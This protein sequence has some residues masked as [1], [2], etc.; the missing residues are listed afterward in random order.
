[1]TKSATQISNQSSGIQLIADFSGVLAIRPK[2]SETNDHDT[3]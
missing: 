3:C 1:M 2:L